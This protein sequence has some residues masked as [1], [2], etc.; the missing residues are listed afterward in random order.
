MIT[1]H[2]IIYSL[3]GLTSDMLETLQSFGP[4][5]YN[6]ECP[7]PEMVTIN[8]FGR[9]PMTVAGRLRPPKLTFFDEQYAFMFK[10]K[11]FDQAIEI[12][13]DLTFTEG[14]L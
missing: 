9:T 13:R 1:E 8:V 11:Y 7:E 12:S 4:G 3:D 14:D 6:L 10:L 2:K 5:I